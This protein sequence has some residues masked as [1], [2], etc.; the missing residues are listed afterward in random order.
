MI[1]TLL[2]VVLLQALVMVVQRVRNRAYRLD[3]LDIYTWAFVVTYILPLLLVDQ[4]YGFVELMESQDY[5]TPNSFSSVPF[6]VALGYLSVVAGFVMARGAARTKI[7]PN[8]APR[9]QG[10][11]QSLDQI[12]LAGGFGLILIASVA[13]LVRSLDYG[14][15]VSYFS[16]RNLIRLKMMDAIGGYSGM[17]EYLFPAATIGFLFILCRFLTRLRRAVARPMDGFLLLLA[18]APALVIEFSSGARGTVLYII[19]FYPILAFAFAIDRMPWR[20]LAAY[21]PLAIVILQ[22]GKAVYAHVS[23]ISGQSD[24]ENAL[25]AVVEAQ[26]DLPLLGMIQS[27]ALNFEHRVFCIPIA[28]EHATHLA[29]L[30]FFKEIP[31][32]LVALLPNSWGIVEEPEDI[33]VFNTVIIMG[34]EAAQST[35]LPPGW[36]AYAIYC[37]QVPGVLVYGLFT[38]IA[39]GLLDKHLRPYVERH[40]IFLATYVLAM[41][42]WVSHFQGG[43]WINFYRNTIVE[44]GV[45]FVMYHVGSRYRPLP[46]APATEGWAS[47]PA[48]LPARAK[49]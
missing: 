6:V 37:L 31:L 2:S 44:L 27:I 45:L 20:L 16:A 17:V 25:A 30:R 24:M 42:L 3:A 34:K 14:G 39:G 8:A 21:A 28:I 23:G 40:W 47:G 9:S 4:P 12:G 48:S 5:L 18:V 43:D 13:Y 10:I 1:V 38:G 15:P 29:D 19:C 35:M 33:Q 36:I 26:A 32:G 7:E 41:N 46:I 11:H 22:A 49:T